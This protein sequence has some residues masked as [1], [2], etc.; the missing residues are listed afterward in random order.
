MNRQE[1]ILKSLAVIE[2]KIQEKLTVESLAG[3]LHFSRYL[4]GQ[5]P[6]PSALVRPCADNMRIWL[7]TCR[8][9]SREE[10]D[11]FW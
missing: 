3:S 11:F 8:M 1:P 5:K 9:K 4:P 2:E 7:K 10:A 6:Q